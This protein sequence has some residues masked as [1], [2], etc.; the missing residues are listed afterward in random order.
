MQRIQAL[1]E[2]HLYKGARAS[3]ARQINRIVEGKD[4]DSPVITRRR[5]SDSGSDSDYSLSF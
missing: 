3:R 5:G 1:D 2:E 4:P